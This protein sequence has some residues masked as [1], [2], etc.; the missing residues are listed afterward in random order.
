MSVGLLEAEYQQT[1]KPTWTS[2]V[3][4]V[5][6][7]QPWRDVE[8]TESGSAAIALEA[9]ALAEAHPESAA[10]W[11]RLAQAE[12][13]AGEAEHS[14]D[15]AQHVFSVAEPSDVPALMSAVRVIR[16]LDK[17]DEIGPSLLERSDIHS[18]TLA[19][20]AARSGNVESATQWLV[21]H[22]HDSAPAVRGWLEL[23]RG[24]SQAALRHLRRASRS[25]VP[26]ASSLVNLGYAYARQGSWRKAIRVTSEALLRDPTSKVA[27]LNLAGFLMTLGDADAAIDVLKS[28]G[29]RGF[30]PDIQ[31]AVVRF[32]LHRDKDP[33][34]ADRALVQLIRRLRVQGETGRIPAVEGLRALIQF[35]YGFLD[36]EEVTR[37][38]RRLLDSY[39]FSDVGT[40]VAYAGF[41]NDASETGEIGRILAELR[42]RGCDENELLGIQV[43][44]KLLKFEFE[45]ALSDAREWDRLE[46][47]HQAPPSLITYL[48][49]IY[50]ADF[51]DVVVYGT[52]S[53]KR[54]PGNEMLANN[55]AYALQTSTALDLH[56]AFCGIL[57]RTRFKW[58]LWDSFS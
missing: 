31:E 17:W 26:Q 3:E 58:P 48:Q 24:D 44:E 34:K 9:R 37:T 47:F 52:A 16:A 15:A 19:L 40:A 27:S 8:Q 39:D 11:A 20:L 54:Q 46:P 55:V 1:T 13:A 51:E 53:L 57:R 29:A 10:M 25:T 2:P 4:D 30:D 32:R 6:W 36:H 45:E 35:Q 42:S 12:L 38:L 23:R 33:Q 41:L 21:D 43:R 56:D 22:E 5:G 50:R 18:G 7:E 14:L 28:A 49:C